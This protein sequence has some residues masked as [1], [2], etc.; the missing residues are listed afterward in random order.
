[1]FREERFNAHQ[2]LLHEGVKENPRVYLIAE[3]Q[4]KLECLNNPFSRRDYNRE[5]ILQHV[6]LHK[7]Y[8]KGGAG[9]VSQTFNR[10]NLGIITKG[11]WLGEENCLLDGSLPQLYS[12]ICV[13]E[14]KALSLDRE[15]FLSKFPPETK[16][17][18][19]RAAYAK[20]HKLREMLQSQNHMKK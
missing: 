5:A 20:L 16:R 12:A 9:N 14:V 17:E 13:G 3:G 15:E 2:V 4:V 11:S 6:H 18:L 7:L 10:C 19:E 1:M 8:E